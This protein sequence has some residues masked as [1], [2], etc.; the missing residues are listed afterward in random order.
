MRII[1]PY[2]VNTIGIKHIARDIKASRELPHPMPKASYMEGPAKGR[3]APTSE[4]K[5]MLAAVT[6]AANVR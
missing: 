5:A 6:E 3:N 1:A 4:R 2:R